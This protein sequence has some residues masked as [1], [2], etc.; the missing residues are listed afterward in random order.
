VVIYYDENLDGQVGAGE[1]VAGFYVRVLAPENKAELARGYTDE[2]GQLSF[3][4]PTVGVVQVAVPLLGF[5]RLVE[6]TKPEVN[7]RIAPPSLPSAIP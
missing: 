1:G 7:I 5:D 3:T 6:A 4:V 2:Q